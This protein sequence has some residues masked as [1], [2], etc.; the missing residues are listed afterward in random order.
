MM[1][2]FLWPTIAAGLATREGAVRVGDAN[3]P[4]RPRPPHARPS[5][6][7]VGA[8]VHQAEAVAR[9]GEASLTGNVV[10]CGL[11][12]ASLDAE[13]G[14][15]ARLMPCVNGPVFPVGTTLQLPRTTP[16]GELSMLL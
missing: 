5:I 2:A 6:G 1:P 13:V 7:E 16:V 12:Q 3:P 9:V 15:L 8:L 11:L 4:M 14:V 10:R